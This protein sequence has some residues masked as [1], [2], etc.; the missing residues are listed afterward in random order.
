[1]N[2]LRLSDRAFFLVLG[3]IYGAVLLWSGIHPHDRFTWF[4]EVA[5][6]LIALVILAATYKRF[7]FSRLVYVLF[8]IHSCIL[9]VGGKY[10]YAENP[11]FEWIRM[12][13]HGERNQYDKLGHFAQG[14]FP[15]FIMRELFVG[16]QVFA[17]KN[18][19]PF[20]VITTTA[21]VTVIYEFIEWWAAILAG[22][23]AD[24]FL[25]T[26]GYV[27]DTQSD[28]LLALIGAVCACFCFRWVTKR[29]VS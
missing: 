13:T 25:G 7:P 16:L 17:K 14:F 28:M 1:M 22:G 9:F 23:S 24:A 11:L 8:L 18:W 5:P 26:Q 6:S 3:V 4:L 29:Q 12:I 21:L 10:T 15:A 20:F 27:W 19:I 2:I